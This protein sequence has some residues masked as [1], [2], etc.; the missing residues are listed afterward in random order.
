MLVFG[1]GSKSSCK[2]IDIRWV[3]KPKKIRF[4]VKKKVIKFRG[5]I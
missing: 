2:T 3:A 4:K 5:A 1:M